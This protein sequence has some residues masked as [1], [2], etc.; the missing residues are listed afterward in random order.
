MIPG[1]RN[2][3]LVL[4]ASFIKSRVQFDPNSL[5]R[6]RPLEGQSPYI[7][8]AGLYYQNNDNGITMSLLYNVI[9]KRISAVGRPSPNQ[10]E[11]IP[12]VY[13]SSRNLI[14][15]TFSKLFGK[16]VCIRG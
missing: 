6:N 1:F 4:N 2:F 5:S 8:N 15:F 12:D 16:Y 9:G 11:D 7:V 3:N 14:D 10:W 13:E